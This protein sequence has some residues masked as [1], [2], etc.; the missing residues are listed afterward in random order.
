MST[1]PKSLYRS[2]LVFVQVP[3]A[4]SQGLDTQK[5]RDDR[6]THPPLNDPTPFPSICCLLPLLE[7]KR[8]R[9]SYEEKIMKI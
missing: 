3:L 4:F 6:P 2:A 7:G 1:L 5:Q 8:G 9:E